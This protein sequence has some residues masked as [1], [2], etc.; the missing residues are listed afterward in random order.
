MYDN[1]YKLI[2]TYANISA[3]RKF[4][5][6]LDDTYIINMQIYLIEKKPNKIN[7]LSSSTNDYAL[8]LLESNPDKI[9]WD[10]LSSNKSYKAMKIIE[11]KY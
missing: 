9:I 5:K 3:R 7:I 8:E 11:K 10:Y 6:L 1:L 4:T 2:I